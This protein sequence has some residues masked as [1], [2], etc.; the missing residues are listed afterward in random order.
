MRIP[1]TVIK[2]S[3]GIFISAGLILG[4]TREIHISEN[5]RIKDGKYDSEFPQEPTAEILQEVMESVKMVSTLAFYAGYG[6]S[7]DRKVTVE[8]INENFIEENFDEEFHFNQPATGT[9]TVIYRYGRQ[10][11]LLT[12]A[13]IIDFPDTLITYHRTDDGAPTKFIRTISFKIRQ[14]I[15]VIDF[16]MG[17][18]FRILAKDHHDD[19][20]LIGKDLSFD[21]PYTI[22]VFNFRMGDAEE[23]TWGDFVYIVG[24]PRG[25]KMVTSALVSQPTR[26]KKAT[27]L[28]DAV[29]NRGFSGGI[30]MAIRDGIPNIELVGMAKSV[31][32]ETKYYLAPD[33]TYK[34]LESS[35]EEIY[36]GKPRIDSYENIYYGITYAVTVNKIKEFIQNNSVVLDDEGYKTEQFFLN[37]N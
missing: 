14:N 9:A 29:F 19:I 31:P 15:S 13:H 23:L 12:C 3:V 33:K 5:M 1:V 8:Q 30:V 17:G 25:E 36:Q 32:A 35:L 27:F 24:Y 4:C 28:L 7:A 16:H 6:F 22:P 20:A 34:Q 18:N 37:T 11:A 26:D 21:T 10:I 2:F